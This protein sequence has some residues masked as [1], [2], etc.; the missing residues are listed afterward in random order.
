MLVRAGGVNGGDWGGKI[1]WRSDLFKSQDVQLHHGNVGNPQ[2]VEGRWAGAGLKSH[3]LNDGID[4]RTSLPK[5]KN[6][7]KKKPKT[8]HEPVTSNRR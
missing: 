7:K 4:I 3:R 1:A 8:K 6:T 2:I 5:D